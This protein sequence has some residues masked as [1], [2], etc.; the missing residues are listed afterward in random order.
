MQ[1]IFLKRK[2]PFD[3]S[4]ARVCVCECLL[5]PVK[6]AIWQDG[7]GYAISRSAAGYPTALL[8]LSHICTERLHARSD[9]LDPYCR[10]CVAMHEDRAAA[11]GAT[12]GSVKA[13]ACLLYRL[14]T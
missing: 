3:I 1:N 6:P 7:G 14:K 4:C 13:A 8:T 5:Q 12:S 2:Q 9:R 11:H 10:L